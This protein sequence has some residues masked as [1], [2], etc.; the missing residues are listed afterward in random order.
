MLMSILT[1]G[2]LSFIACSVDDTPVVVDEDIPESL[3]GV[4]YVEYPA[5]GTAQPDLEEGG[6]Q[7]DH[8]DYTKCVDVLR[9][10]D[11]GTGFWQRFFFAEGQQQPE[12]V[13]GN[14]GMGHYTYSYSNG[15]ID[16]RRKEA[17]GL[18]PQTLTVFMS[19]A[20]TLAARL[21]GSEELLLAKADD[22]TINKFSYW[23]STLTPSG[24]AI[25]YNINEHAI[26]YYGQTM[27]PFTSDNWRQSGG[28]F[29]YTGGAGDQSII[30][31]YGG[32]GYIYVNLPWASGDVQSN[33]PN[34]FCDDITPEKGWELVMN[35]CGS[36]SLANGNFFAVYN[37]WTGTLRFFYYMPEGFS[38]G[39]DHVWQV[40]MTNNM[41]NQSLWGFGLPAEENFGDRTKV[42]ATGTGT[43]VNYVAPWVEHRSNDGLIVPNVGWWAFD[44][45][46]SLYRPNTDLSHD[47]IRLQMRSWTTEHVSLHSTMSATIE[48]S[49]KQV[50]ED[51]GPSASSIAKGIFTSAQVVTGVLSAVRFF[52]D[53][54]LF[55]QGFSAVGSIFG[56]GSQ[57]AGIFGDSTPPFN[58]EV[59]LGLDGTIDTEGFIMSSTP[60]VGVASPTLWLEDFNLENSHLGQGVWNI[61]HH[62]VVDVVKDAAITM[63]NSIV[64]SSFSYYPYF[65]DPT[66]IEVELNPQLFPESEIEWIQ[67]DASCVATKGMGVNGSDSYR[68]GFGLASAYRGKA[69]DGI[70][71]AN[72]SEDC[73]AYVLN[74]INS[75][76]YWEFTGNW[77][78]ELCDYLYKEDK[79][80]L[81][82]P[83]L[84]WDGVFDGTNRGYIIGC[85][86]TDRY[87]IE[88]F[89]LFDWNEV[90]VP[91]LS[92]N[93]L[94]SVKMKGMDEPIL[95]SRN[96]LP[97]IK[98]VS[99][100]QIKDICE[101]IQAHKLSDK[102]ADHRATYDHQVKRISTLTNILLQKCKK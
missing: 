52:Q 62:P 73:P 94:V 23:A 3:L 24:D 80:D 34:G 19:D 56:C 72:L 89:M 17:I 46:L 6:N 10:Y 53:S 90:R 26:K 69:S 45:D 64:F 18:L 8:L 25:D 88:P 97:E 82:F 76:H 12:I 39:N 101:S 50:V 11:G 96:Y 71:I 100:S 15:K 63:K 51:S 86:K 43:M 78:T 77:A 81:S 48:G 54:S 92:V 38:T 98:D 41:A 29:L 70:W 84:T 9:F 99:F 87:A 20:S 27:K 59:S 44:V 65:F 31:T 91:P 93:V 5:T 85:G 79:G 32:R 35:R 95:L 75:P 102:Q 28:I 42:S 60:T 4:W 1:L 30:D 47:N 36:R 14:L 55:G 57:L 74:D 21:D 49:I 58:A 7:P 83:V 33:I 13:W 2:S 22:Q 37:K 16:I 61:R 40:S 68:E 66:S 67:V